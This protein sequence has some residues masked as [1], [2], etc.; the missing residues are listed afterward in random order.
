MAKA[1]RGYLLVSLA[2]LAVTVVVYFIA[3][4][5]SPPPMQILPP[6]TPLPAATRPTVASAF[7][8]PSVTPAFLRVDVAGAVKAPGVYRLPSDS[9][10]EDAIQAAGGAISGSDLDRLNKAAALRDGIQIYVPRLAETN[11]PAPI[12]PLPAVP[13]ASSGAARSA[14][15]VGANYPL[16]LNR[17]TA[18][19]LDTLPGIGPALAGRIIG[20]RPYSTVDDLLNVAGIGQATLDKVR[21][22]VTVR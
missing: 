16:D 6:A 1:A 9:I 12:A 18:E 22:Y 17:A 11:V 7:P 20:G 21:P 15:A 3:R 4:R 19:E 10:V 13:T 2:W 14:P 5:P 8:S